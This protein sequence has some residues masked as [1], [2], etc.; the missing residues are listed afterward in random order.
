MT[1]RAT[2][3]LPAVLLVLCA[4]PVP[5]AAQADGERG[6]L[7]VGLREVVRCPRGAAVPSGTPSSE[8]GCQSAL[9]VQAVFRGSPAEEAGLAPGDTLL[10]VEGEAVGG[11]AGLGPLAEL[12]AGR[13]LELRVGRPGGGRRAL[14]V[15]PA[16]RP[17]APDPVTLRFEGDDG[18]RAFSFRVRPRRLADP[19]DSAPAPAVP[20]LPEAM[21]RVHAAAGL[22]VDEHG[23][24]YLESDDELVRVRQFEEMAVRLRAVRDSAFEAARER[25]R[26]LR[27]APPAAAAGRPWPAQPPGPHRAL[28]A[29]FWTVGPSLARSLRNVEHGM[30]VLEVLP[31][32]PADELGLRSGDVVV[33][34]GE[35]EVRTARDL[36][37]PFSGSGR[38]G[39]IGILWIRSGTAMTDTLPGAS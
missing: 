7:G 32:T 4:A 15:T 30:L 25:I 38:P 2:S 26:D 12:R 23:R 29:E 9:V 36:R 6:W 14:T 20:G 18:P 22:H 28:G 8:D 37:A 19:S 35:T 10:A 1:A 17:P 3:L 34:I 5:A 11:E 31:G 13:S 21:A 39:P 16:P 33:R 27:A 24:V